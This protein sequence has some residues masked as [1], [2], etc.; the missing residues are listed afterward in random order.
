MIDGDVGVLGLLAS[1]VLVGVAVALSRWQRLGVASDL[2]LAVIRAVTQLL[3]VGT[4]LAFVLD[5]DTHLGLSWAWVVAMVLFA[6]YTVRR[7]APGIPSLG[8]IALVAMGLTAG[9]GLAVA[10][11]LG[12]FPLESRTL[13]PVAGMLVGNSMNAA[14][15]TAQRLGDALA[16]GRAEIE[17]RLALG[18][19]SEDAARPFVR[20]VLRTAI[21]PQIETTKA[22]GLVFLPGAMTGLILA[23]VDPLDAVLVQLALMF[24]ILGSVVTV[25]TV[26]A[27]M[28]A[29]NLFTPDHR[30][31]PIA[32]P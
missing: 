15:V 18:L 17:A 24:L 19:S 9:V 12:I 13:V 26:V 31:M 23:G 6:A 30:L 5:P 32:R 7:R 1:L 4:A 10:F 20:S 25:S 29:N 27:T 28:G 22:L 14:V 11:G 8:P 2:V 16:E 3:V 21:T